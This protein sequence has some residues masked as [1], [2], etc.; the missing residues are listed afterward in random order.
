MGLAKQTEPKYKE[1]IRD[2][3]VFDVVCFVPADQHVVC[4]R[5]GDSSAKD[6]SKSLTAVESDALM[7][8]FKRAC[9][10]AVASGSNGTS[11]ATSSTAL[12]SHE[13]KERVEARGDAY[14]KYA[15]FYA[16]AMTGGLPA[17]KRYRFRAN[18]NMMGRYLFLHNP[19]Y[20]DGPQMQLRATVAFDSQADY[21]AFLA[22]NNVDSRNVV[23]SMGSDRVLR[24][25]RVF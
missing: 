6:V 17:G 20:P 4:L 23:A 21:R 2:M 11:S 25:H 8:G 16:Q 22:S 14:I 19:N 9:E 18:L 5:P 15:D 12:P 1:A 13:E 3:V 7:E 10:C 24:I